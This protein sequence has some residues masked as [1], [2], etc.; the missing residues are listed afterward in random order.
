MLDIIR[1]VVETLTPIIVLIFGI[2]I[3]K[4]LKKHEKILWTNQKILEKRLEIYD[5]VIFMLNDIHCFHCYIGNW[6]ELSPFTIIEH[7][8]NLDKIIY[9]YAPLFTDELINSYNDFMKGCYTMFTGWGE[10]AKIN[11]SYIKRKKHNKNWENGWINMFNYEGTKTDEDE[12]NS[13]KIKKEN[14]KLLMKSF[15]ENLEIFQPGDYLLGNGP[16]TNFL[17]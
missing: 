15:K 5:K 4:V 2:K 16:N 11:S 7:K 3:D 12:N 14:Y 13:I 8:R 10:D 17:K 1:L 6:K 9:S